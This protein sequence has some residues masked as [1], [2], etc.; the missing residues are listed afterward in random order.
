MRNCLVRASNT[1]SDM[2]PGAKTFAIALI[3]SPGT[4]VAVASGPPLESLYGAYEVIGRYA[5]EN[6]ETYHG[7]VRLAV[8]GE[9]IEIDRCIDGHP[10]SGIGRE[11]LL[12][13][14]QLRAIEFR[15]AQR[16]VPFVATCTVAGD[17]DNL[18][19]F[20]CYVSPADTP[21]INVPGIET[22]FPIVWPV[23]TDYFVCHEGS[24]GPPRYE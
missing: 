18:P 11:V 14:D 4:S 17:F 16:D 1:G 10:A 2:P 21:A 6:G 7:W 3:L 15:Y 9:E 5:G 22:Y 8:E 20:S 12:G 24:P 23:A 19:R 13:A